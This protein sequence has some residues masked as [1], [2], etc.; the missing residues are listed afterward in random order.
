LYPLDQG[1]MGRRKLVRIGTEPLVRLIP[2]QNPRVRLEVDWTSARFGHDFVKE[3]FKRF[4]LTAVL[5]IPRDD[6]PS[7]KSGVFFEYPFLNSD[8][9]HF[10]RL[11]VIPAKANQ[12]R[13]LA[14]IQ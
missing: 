8:F 3:R 14:G 4:R 13:S 9:T 11:S 12:R 1:S 6:N 5:N 7:A 2:Y 10:S